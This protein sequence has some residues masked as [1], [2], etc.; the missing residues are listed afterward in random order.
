MK[1]CFNSCNAYNPYNNS[2]RSYRNNVKSNQNNNPNV[3][4]GEKIKI[5]FGAKAAMGISGG[6]LGVWG[7]YWLVQGVTHA[8][9]VIFK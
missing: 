2:Q 7:L 4:F 3:G 9:K 5:P 1:V 8:I 6:L